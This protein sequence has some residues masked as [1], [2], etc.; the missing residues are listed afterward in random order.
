MKTAALMAVGLALAAP[1]TAQF[2]ADGGP[3]E[4]LSD[5]AEVFDLERRII[6]TGSVDVRQSDARLQADRIVVN[7]RERAD[8]EQADGQFSSFGKLDTIVATGNV[9]YV[10]PDLRAR[11][12]K[13]TYVAES[14]TVRLEDEVVILRGDDVAR[15]EVFV[16]EV[17]AGR[18]TLDPGSQGR[19]T[20]ILPGGVPNT[21]AEGEEE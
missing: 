15:G 9:F 20:T 13:A 10:R 6:Y 2:S 3:I 16:L 7:Y 21:D 8:G 4:I 5:V 12:R 19:I 1:A 11:G 18:S 14:D 17:E